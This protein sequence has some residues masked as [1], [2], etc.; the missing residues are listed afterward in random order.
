[1][2]GKQAKE[3]SALVVG[4]IKDNG[5]HAVGGVPGLYLL[6]KQ[7]GAARSWVLRY[8][9]H[10]KRREMGLGSFDDVTLAE[11]RAKARAA[12]KQ[13][14]DGIDPI[15]ERNQ[16]LA[17]RKAEA[18]ARTTFAE[19]A[20]SYIEAHT[21]TWRNQKHIA[22]WSA[23]FETYAYPVIGAMPVGDIQTMHVLE[24]LRPIW[25]TKTATATRLRGRIEQVLSSATVA[26][27]R[28]GENPARWRGHLDQ[29]LPKP[30]KIAEVEHHPAMPIDD[31]PAYF[32]RLMGSSGIA[33]KALAFK[34]L[35]AVR[36]QSIRF[37]TWSEVDLGNGVWTIPADHMK[38]GEEFRVPL[39]SHAIKLLRGLPVFEG[40]DLIFP[41][42]R[43]GVMTDMAM[44]AVMRRHGLEA[45][46]HGFRSTFRDWCG[47]RTH[48]PRDL[49]EL[50]LAHELENKTEA[51]YRRGDAL[52][53]RREVMQAWADFVLPGDQ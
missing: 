37:A 30:S 40:V 23:T 5:L 3:L 1:M 15:D 22:Q 6:V 16:A 26:G 34:I 52:E 39:S 50:A 28:K 33:S 12:R 8:S 24:V 51:A 35:T 31:T 4:R 48:F 17:R 19:A 49:V 43:M 11:A 21:P 2:A 44:T 36:S 29:L 20:A 27:Y 42:P 7:D 25:A 53:R 18:A 41:A 45:V 9:L 38:S 47:D 32:A 13:L 46:P 14:A 10:G